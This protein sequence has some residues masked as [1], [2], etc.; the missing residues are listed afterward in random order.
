[1]N[2]PAVLPEASSEP[3]SDRHESGVRRIEADD[4]T[5]TEKLRDSRKEVHGLINQ[6][7]AVR[8]LLQLAERARASGDH[9]A[10]WSYIERATKRTFG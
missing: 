6:I 5:L 10:A 1:M 7:S 2:N 3:Q 8:G 4:E 9:E